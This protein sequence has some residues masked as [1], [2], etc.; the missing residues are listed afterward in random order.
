MQPWTAEECL[1]NPSL[2]FWRQSE[3]ATTRRLEANLVERIRTLCQTASAASCCHRLTN[4]SSE[5]SI[6]SWS[7]KSAAS[8][9]EANL[10]FFLSLCWVYLKCGRQTN[11]QPATTGDGRVLTCF[12]S[13]LLTGWWWHQSGHDCSKLLRTLPL[14]FANTRNADQ[15]LCIVPIN[16]NKTGN[17]FVDPLS[18]QLGRVEAPALGRR[19]GIPR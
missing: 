4:T 9:H 15:R 10:E 8:P 7:L 2:L 1:R 5:E 3:T 6:A 16:H 12:A 18:P 14:T 13:Y 19:T 17:G 11:N